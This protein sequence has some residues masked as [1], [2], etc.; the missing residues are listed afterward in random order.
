LIDSLDFRFAA[1]LREIRILQTDPCLPEK[2]HKLTTVEFYHDPDW[3]VTPSAAGG[4]VNIQAGSER[5]ILRI[6][7]TPECDR[8]EWLVGPDKGPK[9]KVAVLVD[10]VWWAIGSER[11][12]PSQWQDDCLP[13]PREAFIATS[14]DAIWLRLPK[15]RWTDRVF[16]GFC[17]GIHRAYQVKLNECTVAVPLRD[18]G[19]SRELENRD[20]DHFFRVWLEVNG[21]VHEA[22]TAVIHADSPKRELEIRRVSASRAASVLTELSHSTRGPLRRLFKK[23]RP[24]YRRQS[25]SAAGV[26]DEFVKRGLCAVAIFHQVAASEKLFVPRSARRWKARAELAGKQFPETM[27]KVWGMYSRSGR[28][29]RLHITR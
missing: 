27:R 10:R 7:P 18:F 5:T 1:G 29:I 19:D 2:G 15:C 13:V 9:V 4:Y 12:I 20:R 17:S 23:V 24:L 11:Q 16:F 6:A 8:S 3:R 25:R 26:N 22:A 21:K 28:Q 14:E